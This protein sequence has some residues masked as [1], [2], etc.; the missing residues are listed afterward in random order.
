MVFRKWVYFVESK[1]G[2][3]IKNFTFHMENDFNKLKESNRN[4]IMENMTGIDINMLETLLHTTILD[5]S[6]L[7]FNT[8]FRTIYI[9][10]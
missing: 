7:P 4:F 5:H 1:F 6:V 3:Y 2:K 10:T 8:A 9:I